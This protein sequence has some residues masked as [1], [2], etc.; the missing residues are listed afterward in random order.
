MPETLINVNSK[1][2]ELTNAIPANVKSDNKMCCSFGLTINTLHLCH[3][4]YGSINLNH[5]ACDFL[6]TI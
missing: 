5:I 2:I 6:E 3:I 4:I 1:R